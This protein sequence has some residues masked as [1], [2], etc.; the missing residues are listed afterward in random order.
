MWCCE[1]GA[2]MIVEVFLPVCPVSA[3]FSHEHGSGRMVQRKSLLFLF[4]PN[5]SRFHAPP[6][7]SLC[8]AQP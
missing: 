4:G 2:L 7:P 8:S 3:A 5:M 6:W 1:P